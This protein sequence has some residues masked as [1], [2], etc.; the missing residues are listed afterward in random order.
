MQEKKRAYKIWQITENE[1]D[2]RKYEE[3]A[4]QGKRELARA[5]RS[6]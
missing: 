2:K 5:K 4:K 3:K 6:T 1:E